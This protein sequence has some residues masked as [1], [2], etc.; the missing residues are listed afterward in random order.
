MRGAAAG[1]EGEGGP[2]GVGEGE[3]AETVSGR[4]RAGE[5][6]WPVGWDGRSMRA[7]EATRCAAEDRARAPASGD[8][9]L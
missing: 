7:G 9:V 5:G 8:A 2:G 6:E 4:C 3:G 1:N